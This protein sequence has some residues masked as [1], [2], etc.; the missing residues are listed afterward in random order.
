MNE[1][2][3]GVAR[4]ASCACRVVKRCG[5]VKEGEWV[6]YGPSVRAKEY[7]VKPRWSCN[8]AVG[9]GEHEERGG[10]K[11][12]EPARRTGKRS[13]FVRPRALC[14]LALAAFATPNHA[15][16]FCGRNS[17]AILC[18]SSQILR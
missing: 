11:E 9:D 2:R 10:R 18:R 4:G 7:G 8:L 1:E 3:R 6:V 15:H 14:L 5:K 17:D 13:R 12:R 16:A